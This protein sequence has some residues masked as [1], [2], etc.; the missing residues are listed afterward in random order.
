MLTVVEKAMSHCNQVYADL[1]RDG[2]DLYH[3]VRLMILKAEVF[4]VSG[5]CH[6]K[7]KPG[8]MVIRG[9]EGP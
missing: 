8:L 2:A 5:I 3:R 1:I 7:T 9:A 4:A 6:L